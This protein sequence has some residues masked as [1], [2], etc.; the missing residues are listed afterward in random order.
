VKRPSVKPLGEANQNP[1]QEENK[2]K[3]SIKVEYA[4]QQGATASGK[5]LLVKWVDYSSKYG[6]GG[7]MSN[8][9]YVVLF[10]DSTKMVLNQNNFDFVYI[11][12]EKERANKQ[13][14]AL[15][16]LCEHYNFSEYP[17]ALKK[18]VILI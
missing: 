3:F 16:D 10:N 6:V 8:G 15:D 13:K 5:V 2:E 11:R 14:E 17:E 18:K 1:I 4:S 9:S 12:R 7:K